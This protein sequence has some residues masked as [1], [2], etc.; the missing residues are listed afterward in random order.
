MKI[1]ANGQGGK[2]RDTTEAQ[3][4]RKATRAVA[5]AISAQHPQMS[6][7]IVLLHAEDETA[8]HLRSVARQARA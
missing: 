3:T 4:W 8:S 1:F 6:R 7:V 5:D 2:H